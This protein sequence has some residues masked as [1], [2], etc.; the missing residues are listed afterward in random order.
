MQRFKVLLEESVRRRMRAD[1]QLG[2]SL[3]GGLDSSAITRL[4]AN[5]REKNYTFSARFP[6]FAKD[7]GVFIQQ[8][9]MQCNSLHIDVFPDQTRLLKLLDKMLYHHEEPFQS[10]SVFAQY[11]VYERARKENVLVLL[12]GQGADELLAGYFKFLMPYFFELKGSGKRSSLLE[13]MKK[14]QGI[15]LQIGKKDWLQFKFP[16][17]FQ[18]IS[19]LKN[20][21]GRRENVELGPQLRNCKKLKNPFLTHRSLKESLRYNLTQ[22]GLGKLLRFSDRNAMANSIEVRLPFLSHELVDFV[23]SLPSSF[24]FEHGWT[25]SLLRS[26]M[27]QEL[28]QAITWRKDK[29]GFEAPDQDWLRDEKYQVVLQEAKK[30]LISQGWITEQ[31]TNAWNTIVLYRLLQSVN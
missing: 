5:E 11:N 4:M 24:F 31:Y 2:S 22:Q 9:A 7:E 20:A 28:P 29:V 14:Q 26:A 23:L 8:V 12:D 6:G 3:S 19:K 27:D 16:N 25:K 21:S 17:L 15:N 18:F 1:V 13:K 10:A 30:S